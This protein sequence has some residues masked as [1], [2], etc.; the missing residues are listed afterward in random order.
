MYRCNDGFRPSADFPSTCE[1][2]ALWDPPP[3]DHNCTFVE[4]M[5]C[6]ASFIL[7]F[8]THTCTATVDL[9][10]LSRNVSRPDIECPGDI[11][12]FRCSVQSNSETVQLRWLITFPGQDTITIPYINESNLNTL[13]HHSMN[14]TARLTQYTSDQSVESELLLTVLPNVSMNGTILVCMTEDLASRNV[15]V[16]F[17]TSG[18]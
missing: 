10:L 5:T 8:K 3:Q 4:G 14:I 16:S 7:P 13:E 2:T 17:N 18:S 1:S 11:I 15:T 6:L 12:L 9:V